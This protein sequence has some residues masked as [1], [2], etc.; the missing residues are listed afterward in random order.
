MDQSEAY[1]AIIVG[2][3]SGIFLGLFLASLFIKGR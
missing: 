2:L 1:K 3:T